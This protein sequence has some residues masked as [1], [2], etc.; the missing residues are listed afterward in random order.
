MEELKKNLDESITKC[1]CLSLERSKDDPVMKS[2][3]MKTYEKEYRSEEEL[4]CFH[5]VMKSEAMNEYEKEYDSEEKL[6]IEFQRYISNYKLAYEGA[7]KRNMQ[8]DSKG[9]ADSGK[10]K[11]LTIIIRVAAKTV[12][13]P[14]T[15][16]YIFMSSN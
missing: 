15:K 14:T 12:T 10:C 8:V 4:Q 2:E 16:I 6:N 5:R 7:N 13:M 9:I 1:K 3:A 11:F